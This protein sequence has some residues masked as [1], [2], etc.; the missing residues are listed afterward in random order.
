MCTQKKSTTQKKSCFFLLSLLSFVSTKTSSFKIC[1]IKVDIQKKWLKEEIQLNKCF[2]EKYPAFYFLGPNSP[3][4][5]LL[6][7][8]HPSEYSLSQVWSI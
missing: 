6:W 1:L 5:K 8:I 7:E 3:T 2:F 4:T